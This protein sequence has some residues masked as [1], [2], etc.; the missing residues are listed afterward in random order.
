MGRQMSGNAKVNAIRRLSHHHNKSPP[1]PCADVVLFYG[2]MCV[3]VWVLGWYIIGGPCVVGCPCLVSLPTL[4]SLSHPSLRRMMLLSM[5]NH[6]HVSGFPQG[7]LK[8]SCGAKTRW[9]VPTT[10]VDLL[11]HVASPRGLL[12]S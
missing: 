11:A 9:D 3:H 4:A 2:G 5:Q 8:S 7:Y 10:G 12:D 1:C 6:S